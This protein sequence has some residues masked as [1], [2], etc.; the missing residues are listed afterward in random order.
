MILVSRT[1]LCA[2]GARIKTDLEME[3][4]AAR[5]WSLN[6]A[7]AVPHSSPCPQ[8]KEK[9]VKDCFG[10]KPKSWFSRYPASRISATMT[11]FGTKCPN[12]W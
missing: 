7:L 9:I 11:S 10:K 8:C 4:S 5:T 2:R 3:I 12:I 1:T 6:R